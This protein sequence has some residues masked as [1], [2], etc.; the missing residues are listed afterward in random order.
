MRGPAPGLHFP[1]RGAEA[2]LDLHE[3]G[4]VVRIPGLAV[5]EYQERAVH[6]I[7][8][9]HSELIQ[10]AVLVHVYP[11]LVDSLPP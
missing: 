6:R 10:C 7:V 4:V 11:V 2:L 5:A 1:R 9:P 3:P 8:Q